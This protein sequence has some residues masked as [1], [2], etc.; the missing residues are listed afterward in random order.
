MLHGAILGDLVGI[1]FG[2][3]PGYILNFLQGSSLDHQRYLTMWAVRGYNISDPAFLKWLFGKRG[4]NT[5]RAGALT[6]DMLNGNEKILG[7]SA[8][9]KTLNAGSG[10][11]PDMALGYGAGST[12]VGGT[13][14]YVIPPLVWIIISAIAI[15]MSK[16]K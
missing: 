3:L 6:L 1:N 8:R 13:T 16:S 2:E 4:N 12:G 5:Q 11:V 7:E 10:G 9:W 14:P 15:F